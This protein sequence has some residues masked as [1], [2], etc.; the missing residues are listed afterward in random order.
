MTRYYRHEEGAS[1]TAVVELQPEIRSE[2]TIDPNLYGKFAEHL[3]WNIDHG[4]EAQLLYNPT[5]GRWRFRTK[6]ATEDGGYVGTTDPKHRRAMIESHAAHLDFPAAEEL[7]SAVA[8]GL[9]FWWMRLTG[10]TDEV[11]VSP[12]V[13][14]HGNRA[15]RVEIRN[16]SPEAAR[17][18]FQ[19]LYLPLQRTTV[20]EYSITARARTGTKATLTLGLSLVD[21]DGVPTT[22][23]A[24]DAVTVRD[25]WS[26]VD[27]RLGVPPAKEPEPDGLLAVT[28][29]AT[30]DCNVVIDRALL[31]PD[32]HVGGADPDVVGFLRESKLPLLRWPGGNF[33]SDYDWRDGIGPKAERPTTAN[34]A[35]G[36][37][38]PNLF[39]T[40]EFVAFCDAVGCEPLICLNAGTGTA[41]EAAAWVTY[42]NSDADETALGALR[43]AHGYEEPFDVKYWEIGNELY[44]R[45]QPHWT[46]PDG[47]VDR[48]QRFREAILAADPGVT[49]LT[50]GADPDWNEHLIA[51]GGTD[52]R[53]IAT[54]ILAGPTVPDDVDRN[55]FYHALMGYTEQLRERHAELVAEMRAAGIEDP[56]YAITELQLIPFLESDRGTH[57]L[58]PPWRGSRHH[59]ATAELPGKKTIAEAIFDACIIHDC[60]R[61]EGV[62]ELVTH[63]ATVNHGGGLQKHRER[64]WA[65]PCHYGHAMGAVL[66]EKQPLGVTVTCETVSTDRPFDAIESVSDLP[67]L[68]ALAAVDEDELAVMLVHR[69][70]GVGD[71]ETTLDLAGLVQDGTAAVTTIDAETMHAENT[72]ENP[73]RIA[74]RTTT[75]PVRGDEVV[76]TVPEY[77]LVQVV[78]TGKE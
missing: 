66:F 44:G 69:G 59:P 10:G 64:V 45:W 18:I 19:W 17:G 22:K 4:M 21:E 20:Y 25:E 58:P 50:C 51:E 61:S 46:T 31:Y 48:Y 33:V 40:D 49:V 39:G 70:S 63:S 2:A 36:G 16:A 23:L 9:A 73:T 29:S 8:D 32:D 13:G 47:Y 5:F 12:D 7:E 53:T 34:P 68:D 57:V 15:Q 72:L 65:D 1:G 77:G 37:V 38:E 78:V 43:A 28:I 27:G 11:V 62:A 3:G 67:V 74:P 24:S 35:W 14:P 52:I 6:N 30:A 55:D 71:V 60:I 26:T 75:R 56:H 41:A 54:H 42:C 76:V